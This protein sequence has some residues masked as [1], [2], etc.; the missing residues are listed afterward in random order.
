MLDTLFSAPEYVAVAKL[1]GLYACFAHTTSEPCADAN[2]G[3][4]YDCC[5]NR[6]LGPSPRNMYVG[7]ASRK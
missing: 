7:E 1:I 5:K 4:D 3:C 2:N 6:C